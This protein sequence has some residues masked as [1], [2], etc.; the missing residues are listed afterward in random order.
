MPLIKAN[1][2]NINY[3]VHG[4]GTPVVLIGGL[5]SHLQS[6]ATQIPIYSEYFKVIVFDN[7]GMGKTDKPDTQYS[8]EMMAD[9]T[10][11][12]L[13]KLDLERAS[14]IGKSM[15][16]MIAQWMGIKYPQRVNKLVMG[17]TT[18]SRDEVGNQIIKTGREIAEKAGMKT[19][20]LTALFLGYSR[21]YIEDNIDAIKQNM[22]AV[23]ESKEYL[24]GYIRQSGACEKHDILDLIPKI[25]AQS[26][27]MYG[28][29]DFIT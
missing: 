29:N 19:V 1:D 23:T 14:F 22:S 6:W 28:K 5:G 20:W 10:A 27:V 11:A 17:C 7:R 24:T 4:T 12:L 3:E 21:K 2:I 9:D 8:I 18:A 15:G 25:R 16:G 26:L 13:E